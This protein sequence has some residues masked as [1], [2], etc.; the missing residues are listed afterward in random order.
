MVSEV[1]AG[2]RDAVVFW[3]KSWIRDMKDLHEVRYWDMMA[4][5]CESQT[6]CVYTDLKDF[7]QNLESHFREKSYRIRRKYLKSDD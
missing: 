7:S 4:K 6:K 3:S 1:V 2:E 5:R